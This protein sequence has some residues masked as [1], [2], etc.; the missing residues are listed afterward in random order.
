[1]QDIGFKAVKL[2]NSSFSLKYPEQSR[3]SLE[4]NILTYY[5]D[6][7]VTIYLYIYN[8]TI[9]CNK[10]MVH[11]FEHTIHYYSY[12]NLILFFRDTN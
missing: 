11:Y 2:A 9:K 12:I 5:N 4:I 10:Q 3:I 6:S 1:V 7:V 8:N